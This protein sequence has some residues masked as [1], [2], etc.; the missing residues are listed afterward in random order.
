MKKG[1]KLAAVQMAPRSFFGMVMQVSGL[2]TF[3][4]GPFLAP[5]MVN[6]DI[7]PLGP[8]IKFNTGNRPWLFQA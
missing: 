4:A 6:P 7:Y 2:S 1:L 8:G 5:G 3:R